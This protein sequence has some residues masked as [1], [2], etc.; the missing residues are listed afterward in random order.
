MKRKTAGWIAILLCVLLCSQTFVSYADP[1][2]DDVRDE[3]DETQEEL[4]EVTATI[5]ELAAEQN[6]VASEIEEINEALVTVITEV[7][8]IKAS[9]EQK[10]AEIA[11]AT[12]RYEAAVA[13]ANEQYE[14]MKIRIQYM[15][16]AGEPDYLS[17]LMQS[18][19]I[20]EVLTK[21]DYVQNLYE[22]DRNMLTEYRD[23]IAQVEELRT[24]LE[25]EQAELLELQADYEEE[26]M[27]ME[28]VM[29]ELQAL[30]DEYDAQIAAA[31]ALAA[32]YA[33]KI[34]EQ[35]AEIARMEEEAR[36]AAEEAARRAAEEAARRAAQESVAG[37]ASTG[38]VTATN[39]ATYDVS[40]IYAANGSDLGKSIAVFA[41]QFIGNPYVPGG[42]SLTEGADCSGFVF[43]VYKEFGYAVPRTSYSLRSAGTEVAYENAQ[44][45]DI[46]CYP[47]HVA[48][49]I[50]NGLIVHASSIKTGIKISNANYRG[51]LAVR[52]L[53]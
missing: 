26:Q 16:E 4:D 9:V 2:I 33:Q 15:Y 23:T 46:I 47:G 6:D 42:T 53:I 5:E 44:P 45:G 29:E 1:S 34:E 35:N 13:T 17:M 8:V 37:S 50:G 7:E 28:G 19:S 3:R 41:C 49:Y 36:R 30:S 51:I 10:E 24:S 27:Y 32:E 43:S 25:A 18:G 38:V 48:I 11:E 39:S 14:A 12:V 20:S 40:S 21:A 52:R 31:E 22:Y